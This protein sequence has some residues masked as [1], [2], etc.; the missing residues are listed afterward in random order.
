MAAIAGSKIISSHDCPFQV[1]S[2]ERAI[3]GFEKKAVRGE[4]KLIDW[5]RTCCSSLNLQVDHTYDSA[6]MLKVPTRFQGQEI[7]Q[8]LVRAG[9]C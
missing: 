4:M 9:Q 2:N 8:Q 6:Y 7:V 1:P 5:D 3:R